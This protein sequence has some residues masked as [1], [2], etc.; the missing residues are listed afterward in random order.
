MWFLLNSRML[1]IWPEL[2]LVGLGKLLLDCIIKG[3]EKVLGDIDM[4]FIGQLDEL[5]LITC[6][7]A[8]FDEGLSY[9]DIAYV[10]MRE[11][12]RN[13]LHQKYLLQLS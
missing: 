10:P 6:S 7:F 5:L 13:L 1:L 3:I 4:V 11:F 12:S 9:L 8:Y 2:K